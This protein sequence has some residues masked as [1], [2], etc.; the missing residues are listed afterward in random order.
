[1]I[2]GNP[3]TAGGGGGA[4]LNIDYGTSAPADTSKLWVPLAIK[5]KAVECSPAMQY[6][7][8]YL[9]Q[10][11]A[12]AP[13][14]QT[15][16][17]KKDDN[18]ILTYGTNS[19]YYLYDIPSKTFTTTTAYAKRSYGGAGLICVGD[20]FYNFG[21]ASGNSKYK[22]IEK[23]NM[24]T[25]EKTSLSAT[26]SLARSY[27]ACAEVNGKIYIIGGYI[28]SYNDA[29]DRIDVFDTATDT[30]KQYS[31]NFS[32]KYNAVQQ[33]AAAVGT[34]IYVFGGGNDGKSISKIDTVAG[35]FS[36]LSAKL[37]YSNPR[38]YC[39]EGNAIAYGNKIYIFYASTYNDSGNNPI[40]VFD[41]ATQTVTTLPYTFGKNY[42]CPVLVGDK[43]YIFAK[44]N[45]T[46]STNDGVVHC[47]TIETLLSQNNLFV[48]TDF[49]FDGFW[50]A[51]NGK[52]AQIKV[53]P[54]NV[55]LGDHNGVAQLTNAYLHNGSNW[56]SLSGESMTADMLNALATLGVT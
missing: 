50:A 15:F 30:C 6:G 41:V 23:F 5:P 43:V 17:V 9:T 26:L 37:P 33:S 28:G 34:D 55:Y 54:I 18:T 4:S 42:G 2:I 31:V 3:I 27:A 38:S 51:I 39:D 36:I 22:T 1:M 16:A 21:G 49:G 48:Q 53:K 19:T 25:G 32:A 44:E 7:N 40:A 11:I 10:S 13:Y 46:S 56:V 24:N 52:D 12:I 45:A 35:T 20:Y 8:E 14:E 29:T 47:F